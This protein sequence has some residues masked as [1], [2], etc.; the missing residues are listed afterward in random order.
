MDVTDDLKLRVLRQKRPQ[1][2]AQNSVI[3]GNANSFFFFHGKTLL[4][5]C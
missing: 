5:F 2:L 4:C 1:T 3:F